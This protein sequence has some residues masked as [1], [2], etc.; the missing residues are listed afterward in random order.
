MVIINKK[1]S[2]FL[3]LNSAYSDRGVEYV[4]Y[5]LYGRGHFKKKDA[6]PRASWTEVKGQCGWMGGSPRFFPWAF[7]VHGHEERVGAKAGRE[8]GVHLRM[9]PV[10][11]AFCCV[12]R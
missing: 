7:D 1:D 6:R 2:Q 10:G 5:S 8:G 9:C 11:N 4:E 3:V 12:G